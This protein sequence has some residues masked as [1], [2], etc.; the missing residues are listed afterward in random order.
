M[1]LW[2]AVKEDIRGASHLTISQRN[3]QFADRWVR[4]LVCD[5]AA[6]K[7]YQGSGIFTRRGLSYCAACWLLNAFYCLWWHCHWSIRAVHL[8][9][10]NTFCCPACWSLKIC[11]LITRGTNLHTIAVLST[12]QS[13]RREKESADLLQ[14]LF[15]EDE[16]YMICTHH[17][18]QLCVSMLSTAGERPR[19]R[20]YCSSSSEEINPSK[21]T[22]IISK[23]RWQRSLVNN[24]VGWC[25]VIFLIASRGSNVD[26]LFSAKVC[27]QIQ[28]VSSR[29]IHLSVLPF[30]KYR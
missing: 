28:V 27:A 15:R 23:T 24:M 25:T 11:K 17:L 21:F 8:T 13:R 22:S 10:Q 26:C 14:Q 29:L 3:P 18:T 19:L 1:S 4:F 30:L 20:T 12:K 9:F 2:S 7:C 5:G 6:T 16:S